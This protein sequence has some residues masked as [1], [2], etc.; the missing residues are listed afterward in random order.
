MSGKP[1][2]TDKEKAKAKELIATGRYTLVNIGKRYG[3]SAGVMLGLKKEMEQE[4][5]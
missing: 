4:E 2:L 5:C 3:V 1:L